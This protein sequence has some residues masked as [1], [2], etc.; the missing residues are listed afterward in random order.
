MADVSFDYF[1]H[2]QQRKQVCCQSTLFP[3]RTN[4]PS[5]L[6]SLASA[7]HMSAL[8]PITSPFLYAVARTLVWGLVFTAHIC[9]PPPP[10]TSPHSSSSGHCKDSSLSCSVL[11]F[12]TSRQHTHLFSSI[13]S[14]PILSYPIR[15]NPNPILLSNPQPSPPHL[16]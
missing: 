15:F 14:Y 10:L 3:S 11:S 5:H 1:D 2:P 7:I 6:P 8:P 13:L 16:S 12:L 4:L 9:S